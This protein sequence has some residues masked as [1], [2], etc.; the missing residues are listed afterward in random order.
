MA[1]S[2]DTVDRCVN[3][4]CVC[5]CAC[6]CVGGS[7]GTFKPNKHGDAKRAVRR[8]KNGGGDVTLGQ[9]EHIKQLRPMRHP[10]LTGAGSDATA[11]NT[12]ADMFVS[13]RSALA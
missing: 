12:V 4:V 8:P 1:G 6:V 3:C 5:V 10:E 7:F 2:E 13:L 9:D 11:S